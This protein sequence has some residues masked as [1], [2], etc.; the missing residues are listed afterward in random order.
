MT[1]HKERG[2]VEHL[3]EGHA[4]RPHIDF[5]VVRL[6][7]ILF[8]DRYGIADKQLGCAIVSRDDILG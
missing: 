1:Y 6:V 7:V 5:V 3:C 2:A 4:E 8:Q